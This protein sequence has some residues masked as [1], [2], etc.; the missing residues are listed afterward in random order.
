MKELT[1]H[2]SSD[3]RWRDTPSSGTKA[4]PPARRPAGY[5]EPFSMRSSPT[6]VARDG[7]LTL[8]GLGRRRSLEQCARWGALR[9]HARRG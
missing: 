3:R 1:T 2:D 7:E 6:G 8:G 9:P 5:G 4:A